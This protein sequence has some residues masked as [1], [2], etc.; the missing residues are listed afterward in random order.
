MNCQKHYSSCQSGGPLKVLFCGHS[1]CK[2]AL[3]EMLKGSTLQR[4]CPVCGQ[5]VARKAM[6]AFS[7][8][9]KAK[10]AKGQGIGGSKTREQWIAELQSKKSLPASPASA[11]IQPIGI[12]IA[13][14][15]LASCSLLG[16]RKSEVTESSMPLEQHENPSEAAPKTDR[17]DP[18]TRIGSEQPGPVRPRRDPAKRREITKVRVKEASHSPRVVEEGLIKLSSLEPKKAKAATA[19]KR[20]SASVVPKQ[21]KLQPSKERAT[22]SIVSI[23]GNKNCSITVSK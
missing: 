17:P 14:P 18:S 9:R 3:E 22:I 2:P 19:S 20:P 16:K 21:V 12:S 7:N 11:R 1:V 13:A 15:M 10:L 6:R 4:V 5:L 8:H 23:K